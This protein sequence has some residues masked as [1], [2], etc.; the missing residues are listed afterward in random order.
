MSL[1]L[2]S[3]I[4]DFLEYQVG[5]KENLVIRLHVRFVVSKRNIWTQHLV[6]PLKCVRSSCELCAYTQLEVYKQQYSIVQSYETT[7]SVQSFNAGKQ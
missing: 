1:T 6:L 7:I 2:T 5:M 4:T 3:Y